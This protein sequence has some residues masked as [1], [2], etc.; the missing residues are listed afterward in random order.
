V[1]GLIL[2]KTFAL[3]IMGGVFLLEVLSSLIQILSKK[4]L[5]KK[6]F[7]VAPFHLWLQ[8]IGWEEPKIVM[9]LWIIEIVFVFLGLMI[10]FSK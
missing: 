7:P 6:A 9:R 4:F 5:K 10:S 3:P 2:G 8:L 1:I